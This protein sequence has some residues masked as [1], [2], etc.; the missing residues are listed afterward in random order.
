MTLKASKAVPISSNFKEQISRS[1]LLMSDTLVYIDASDYDSTT[2][3]QLIEGLRG[4]FGTNSTVIKTYLDAFCTDSL[5]AWSSIL[6]YYGL[7]PEA[8]QPSRAQKPNIDHSLIHAIFTE[9]LGLTAQQRKQLTIVIV[10]GWSDFNPVIETLKNVV[11]QI[12][13]CSKQEFHERYKTTARFISYE[14]L[15]GTHDTESFENANNFLIS[16]LQELQCSSNKRL[17]VTELQEYLVVK[18]PDYWP[19]RYGFYTTSGLLESLG[20][21]VKQPLF[22][23]SLLQHFLG[24]PPPVG[25]SSAVRPESPRAT[26]RRSGHKPGLRDRSPR[27]R[28]NNWSSRSRSRISSPQP[29]VVLSSGSTSSKSTSS[30]VNPGR[31]VRC[32][33]AQRSVRRTSS[34]S[35]R[36]STPP[37][38]LTP[39][40][41]PLSS[42]PRI[43]SPVSKTS[44]ST[45]SIVFTQN[46]NP[47]APR[48]Q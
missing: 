20:V 1:S 16:V 15:I 42:P 22:V 13:V 8:I 33:S 31:V 6:Y 29:E 32:S 9:L 41:S 38:N 30:N 39:P 28:S 14:M 7:M 27:S 37:L 19:M 26:S 11:K 4:M 18:D 46:N 48:R 5:D 17:T 40:I 25:S 44:T 36:P 24:T 2:G 21:S 34:P 23:N 35:S 3:G 12:I 43:S 47:F 45:H 10:I